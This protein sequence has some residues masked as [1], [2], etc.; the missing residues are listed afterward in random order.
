MLKAMSNSKFFS[1]FLLG[2][3]IFVI[4]I[5]FLFWGIAPPSNQVAGV[6]ATIEGERILLDEFY[7]KYDIEYKRLREIYKTEEELEKLNIKESVLSTLIDRTVLLVVAE[8]AGIGVTDNE[9]RDVIINQPYFQSN[10][11][12]DPILYERLLN[13]NR[14]NPQGF[15]EEV[16]GDIIVTKMSRIIGETAELTPDELNLLNSI[17]E[18]KAQ[19]TET[20]LATKRNQAVKVYIE[21]IKQTLDIKVNTDLIL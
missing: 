20:F 15:E 3:I 11:V 18:G 8:D 13:R 10:G 2:G 7:Q 19:L 5:S 16:R 4:T 9:V 17:Q 21:G 6:L 12:F 14:M 1:V